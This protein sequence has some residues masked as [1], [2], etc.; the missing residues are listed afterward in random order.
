MNFTKV[1]IVIF[2]PVNDA[3]AVRNALGNA[4]AGCIGEYSF[5]SYSTIGKG[6]FIPSENTNP[7]IGTP[8]QPE[9]VEEERIEIV[10]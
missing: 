1:K 9:V 3:D 6:R 7:H 4:G 2:V 8:N 5:C 10:C